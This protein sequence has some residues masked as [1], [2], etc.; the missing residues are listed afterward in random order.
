MNKHICKL[1]LIAT[2]IT[3][4]TGCSSNPHNPIIP[5]DSVSIQ[6]LPIA[7]ISST[8]TNR[9][10]LGIWSI[11]LNPNMKTI[12]ANPNRDISGWTKNHLNV[13][14]FV[15]APTPQL[16]SYDP[17]LNIY[18]IDVT[19]NNNSNYDGYD[20]RLIIHTT[21][22]GILLL[23]DD[24]WTPLWDELGGSLINPF[25]AYARLEPK[26]KF[27]AHTSH[28][29]RLQIYLPAG[30][31][32][33]S[34]AIDASSGGNCP[35]PYLIRNFTQGTLYDIIDSETTVS[36]EVYDWQDDACL[37]RLYCPQITDTWTEYFEQVS[38]NEWQLNLINK[39]GAPEGEYLG[40][41]MATSPDLGSL[42]LYDLV[43]ISVSLFPTPDTDPPVWKDNKGESIEDKDSIIYIETYDKKIK[44]GWPHAEDLTSPPVRYYV[45]KDGDNNPWNQSPVIITS[46]TSY[47]FTNL[48]NGQNY[49]FAVRCSDSANPPNFGIDS[50][51]IYG[52][53]RPEKRIVFAN[54]EW[55]VSN[56]YGGPGP[57]YY[58]ADNAWVDPQGQLHLK[59]EYSGFLGKYICSELM[60]DE[61]ITYSDFITYVAS[62]YDDYHQN[63]V[64]GLFTFRE[65]NLEG[66]NELD[67]EFSQ[68]AG[69]M[70]TND[71]LWYSIQ[72]WADD[73][74]HHRRSCK[75]NLTGDYTTHH[76]TWMPNHHVDFLSYHGH[77][78]TLPDPSYLITPPWEVDDDHVPLPNGKDR[79]LINFY[80]YKGYPLP[81]YQSAEFIIKGFKI[82][83]L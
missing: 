56:R 46:S 47:E 57:N 58:S 24:G 10:L 69:E 74:P 6:D 11:E 80:L 36:M 13:K 25:R 41:V 17:V 33:V 28:T 22:R 34:F 44:V 50:S 32:S 7:E 15:P 76:L 71:D 73:P 16:I 21:D 31:G 37:V 78:E 40:V 64:C 8:E 3:L 4:I 79:F 77:Y 65:G 61:P 68:W 42:V 60:M 23:N 20:V 27:A 35:E 12:I 29:E 38:D 54:K 52:S 55:I 53:P 26:H 39:A 9:T 45:Y 70:G 62:K 43:N 2:I 81:D 63:I 1:F 51:V 19:I 14:P 18:D 5:P 49:W 83:D 67:I 30:W 59:I 75:S 72:P 48:N 82:K 66:G